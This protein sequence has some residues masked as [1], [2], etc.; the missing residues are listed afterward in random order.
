M[1]ML[2]AIRMNAE[3]NDDED[4]DDDMVNMIECMTID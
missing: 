4:D 3:D 1:T 2:A